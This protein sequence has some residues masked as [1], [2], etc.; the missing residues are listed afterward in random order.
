MFNI[1]LDMICENAIS[2]E[3]IL[4]FKFEKIMFHILSAFVVNNFEQMP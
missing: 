1:I 4:A 3:Q 2:Y